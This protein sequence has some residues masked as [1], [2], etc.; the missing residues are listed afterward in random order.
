M[1]HYRTTSTLSLTLC[2]MGGVS[3]SHNNELYIPHFSVPNEAG[4][5]QLG[6]RKEAAR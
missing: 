3:Y 4:A 2:G 6:M 5:F 1:S